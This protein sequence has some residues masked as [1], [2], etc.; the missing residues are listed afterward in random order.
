MICRQSHGFTEYFHTHHSFNTVMIWGP[1]W[2][3]C[4]P[5]VILPQSFLQLSV[6]QV[7][8]SLGPSPLPGHLSEAPSHYGP[9]RS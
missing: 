4:L 5:L 9:S 8:W 7:L 1:E 2:S 3:A 6:M